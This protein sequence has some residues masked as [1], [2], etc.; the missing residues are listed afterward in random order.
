MSSWPEHAAQLSVS[1]RPLTQTDPVTLSIRCV[2]CGLMLS[3]YVE[4]SSAPPT[5]PPGYELQQVIMSA[6]LSS[7]TAGDLPG[8]I[9]RVRV[10]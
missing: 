6:R 10:A 9:V 5:E 3:V 4:P 1:E 2:S 8:N 7:G